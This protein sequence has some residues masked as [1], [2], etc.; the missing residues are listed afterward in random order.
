MDLETAG[1]LPANLRI[2]PA[3]SLGNGDERSQEGHG[4]RQ[5]HRG[6]QRKAR[7][8]AVEHG[9]DLV[10]DLE[11]NADLGFFRRGPEVWRRHDLRQRQ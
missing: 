1:G 3:D 10:A 2:E 9:D 11:G 5:G 8:A 6:V 4:L 7:E